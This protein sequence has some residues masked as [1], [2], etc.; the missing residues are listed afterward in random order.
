M[1]VNINGGY[2]LSRC[3]LSSLSQ[4]T[5]NEV[6]SSKFLGKGIKSRPGKAARKSDHEPIVIY[7]H[8]AMAA[9]ANVASYHEGPLLHTIHHEQ[10][11]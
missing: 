6:Y 8:C 10:R 1:V 2:Y 3:P 9:A 4:I 7:I 11:V 5:T